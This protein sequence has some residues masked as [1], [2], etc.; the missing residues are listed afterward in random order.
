MSTLREYIHSFPP[1]DQVVLLNAKV[2][3]CIDVIGVFRED[4]VSGKELVYFL[5]VVKIQDYL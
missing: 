5:K 4:N 1:K 2:H 3:K